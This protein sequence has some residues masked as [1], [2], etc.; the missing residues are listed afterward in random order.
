MSRQ[1]ACRWPKVSHTESPSITITVTAP[2][3]AKSPEMTALAQRHISCFPS[4]RS[5]CLKIGMNAAVSAPSPRRRRKRLGTW[6]AHIKALATSVLPMKAAYAISRT[7]PSTRLVKVA[8]ANAPED[9]NI[10]DMRSA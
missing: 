8:A 4:C 6:K 9:F 5:L 3:A 7:M 10:C 2:A 1:S